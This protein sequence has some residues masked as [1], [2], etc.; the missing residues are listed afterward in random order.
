MQTFVFETMKQGLKKRKIELKN[1]FAKYHPKCKQ[2][3]KR[4]DEKETA[5]I[6]G[7]QFIKNHPGFCSARCY[8]KHTTGI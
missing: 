4:Y 7:K 2:C 1:A 8:T 3:G 6:F 5:R